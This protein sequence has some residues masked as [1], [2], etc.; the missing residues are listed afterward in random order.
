MPVPVF[1][2]SVETHFQY[3]GQLKSPETVLSQEELEA[4][5]DDWDYAKADVNVLDQ[6][7]F[8]VTVG[9]LAEAEYVKNI[10]DSFGWSAS[11]ERVNLK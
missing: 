7:E 11:I 10:L 9:T 5:N 8:S 6:D 4:Y 3:D 1:R 2:V